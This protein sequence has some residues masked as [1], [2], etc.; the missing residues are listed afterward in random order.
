MT[1]AIL[2]NT[3]KTGLYP[4]DAE[5]IGPFAIHETI[6][7]GGHTLTHLFTGL[8]ILHHIDSALAHWIAGEL[9]AI[10]DWYFGWIDFQPG[11]EYVARVAQSKAWLLDRNFR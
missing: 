6:G 4:V 8:A 1:Q 9:N 2:V 10:D 3:N 5:I 7:G 11:G